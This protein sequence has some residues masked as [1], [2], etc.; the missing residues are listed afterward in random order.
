MQTPKNSQESPFRRF[1]KRAFAAAIATST[2]E[3]C[4]IPIDTAK[5]RL[6]IQGQLGKGKGVGDRLPYTGMLNC[7]RRISV[8]EGVKGLFVGV[9]PAIFRQLTYG[10]ARLALYQPIRN[11]YDDQYKK[12][13]SQS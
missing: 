9:T 13:F 7:L 5:V 1:A 12:M 8:E 10:T 11:F 4:T 3:I 6:Q 2:A